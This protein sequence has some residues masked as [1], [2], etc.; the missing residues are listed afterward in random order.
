MGIA[1]SLINIISG[2]FP[3]IGLP[4]KLGI[5][6]AVGLAL[7]IIIVVIPNNFI[8][9]DKVFKFIW[10]NLVPGFIKTPI[11]TVKNLLFPFGKKDEFVSQPLKYKKQLNNDG[12][13]GWVPYYGKP[14]RLCE[15]DKDCPTFQKCEEDKCIIPMGV[16]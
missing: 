4:L 6:G 10:D 14:G 3:P 5:D 15:K 11:M 1:I 12:G 8:N 9:W 2:I 13:I 7:L 16:Y